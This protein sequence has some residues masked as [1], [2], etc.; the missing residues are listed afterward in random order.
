MLKMSSEFIPPNDII[1]SE[2]KRKKFSE[3]YVSL[4]SQIQLYINKSGYKEDVVINDILLGYTLVDYFSDIDRL[5][6]FHNIEHI[7]SIKL[8]SYTVYWLL[9]RKPI[10]LKS[11]RKELMHINERFA[12][13]LV[14]DF[15]S[16]Q[17]KNHL[18]IRNESGLEAFKELLYYFFKFRQFTAQDIELMLTAFFAGQIYQETN[19]DLSGFLPSS[20][21]DGIDSHKS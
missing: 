4:Y 5:K 2:E 13:A 3:R 12:L 17:G 10:Q 20:D 1:N 21:Y 11:N 19:M 18:A 9:R 16:S 6:I 14:L 8:I 7:N 15:L